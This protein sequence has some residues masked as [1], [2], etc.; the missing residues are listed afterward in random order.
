MW[1]PCLH[2]NA[3]QHLLICKY[4]KVT[5]ILA[6]PLSD[7]CA[8]KNICIMYHSKIPL[9]KKELD[10]SLTLWRKCYEQKINLLI[11][12]VKFYCFFRQQLSMRHASHR[13]GFRSVAGICQE[14]SVASVFAWTMVYHVWSAMLEAYH[15]LH[16]QRKSIT[17]LEEAL[18]VIWDSL[19]RNWSTRLLK[20]SHYDWRDAQKLTVNNLSTQSD[21][22][23]SDIIVKYCYVTRKHSVFSVTLYCCVSAQMFFSARKLL[24]G[25]AKISITLSY[26]KVIKWHLI[27]KC[28]YDSHVVMLACDLFALANLLVLNYAYAMVQH[29]CVGMLKKTTVMGHVG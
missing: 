4:N 28:R 23:T 29:N 11:I 24:I 1:L 6:W 15:K 18:L 19:H 25:H 7:F 13:N 20:A 3:K 26:L 5:D 21:C 8:L 14:W 10:A 27:F 12:L 2:L 16:P 9:F 22:E 17:E